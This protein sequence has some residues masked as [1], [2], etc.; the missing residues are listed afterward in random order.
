[1]VETHL[2]KVHFVGKFWFVATKKEA[3][4]QHGVHNFVHKNNFDEDVI[5]L[6]TDIRPSQTKVASC[7]RKTVSSQEMWLY[8]KRYD[9]GSS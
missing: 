5:F 1:M 6:S 7:E 2:S 3:E 9:L 4:K 8:I